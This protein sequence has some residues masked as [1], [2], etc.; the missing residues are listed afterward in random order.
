MSKSH[1]PSSLAAATK[2]VVDAVQTTFGAGVVVLFFF[3]LTLILLASGL[4]NLAPEIRGN[5]IELLVWLMVGIVMCFVLLRILKPSGLAGPPQP[6]TEQI[7][8][9]NSKIT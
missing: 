9:K 2:V 3:G 8:F 5:L 6:E 7:K 1:T 4:G